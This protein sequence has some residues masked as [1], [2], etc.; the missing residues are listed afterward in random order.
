MG[1]SLGDEE[2]DDNPLVDVD[3]D[4]DVLGFPEVDEEGDPDIDA[5]PLEL[6]PI[7]MLWLELTDALGLELAVIDELA[8]LDADA[9][10][11]AVVDGQADGG[12]DG[13]LD[14][15]PAGENAATS[16]ALAEDELVGDTCVSV[17]NDANATPTRADAINSSER[18]GDDM[19]DVT[20]S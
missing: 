3:A 18:M 12:C 11:D 15:L 6:E 14:V 5:L 16:D 19:F 10:W 9:D 13:E 7:A 2:V 4:A 20:V 1:S 17:E 8:E